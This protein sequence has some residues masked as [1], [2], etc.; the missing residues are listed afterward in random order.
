[1]PF[2]GGQLFKLK[3]FYVDKYKDLL[4]MGGGNMGTHIFFSSRKWFI[5]KT[6]IKSYL[7]IKDLFHFIYTEEALLFFSGIIS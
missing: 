3:L 2:F 6:N 4:N 1:M 7:H 5:D